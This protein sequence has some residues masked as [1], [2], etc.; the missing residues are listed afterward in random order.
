MLWVLQRFVLS[1]SSHFSETLRL[2][3]KPVADS[4]QSQVVLATCHG[5][6]GRQLINAQF[7]VLII[8]EATQALEAVRPRLPLTHTYL[9]PS[10]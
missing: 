6:G 3:N 10:H 8:D 9:T 5:A 1:S 7:D 2:R 4:L